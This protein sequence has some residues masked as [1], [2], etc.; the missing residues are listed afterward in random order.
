MAP[1]PYGSGSI[2]LL[3][4]AAQSVLAVSPPPSSAGLPRLGPPQALSP[5]RMD[6]HLA[7]RLALPCAG[8]GAALGRGCFGSRW[9]QLGGCRQR[10]MA[11]A[12]P[13]L[14]QRLC[15]RSVTTSA[16][17]YRGEGGTLQ[18][19]FCVGKPSSC[20][21]VGVL[22]VTPLCDLLLSA[23]SCPAG[24]LHSGAGG[25]GTSSAS[26]VA[27][28]QWALLFSRPGTISSAESR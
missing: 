23:G 21:V 22:R 10:S 8:A 27:E 26:P 25:C 11:M 18:R 14:P 16:C 5:C 6:G 24:G 7:P 12:C 19:E 1:A 4:T 15:E 20:R 17:G 3:L 13:A 28:Q 2:W 9:W